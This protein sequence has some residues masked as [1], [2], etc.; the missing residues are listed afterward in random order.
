M[1]ALYLILN[2][3]DVVLAEINAGKNCV[4]RQF[5]QVLLKL[6]ILPLCE[7]VMANESFQLWF[8]VLEKLPGG[9]LIVHDFQGLLVSAIF[10]LSNNLITYGFPLDNLIRSQLQWTNVQSVDT[11]A[12]TLS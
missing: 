7:I 10:S 12:A 1:H 11:T 4:A 3:H 8:Q 6:L 2:L 9:S 5:F